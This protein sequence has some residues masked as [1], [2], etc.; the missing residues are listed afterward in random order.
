MRIAARKRDNEKKICRDDK[1]DLVELTAACFQHFTSYKISFQSIRFSTSITRTLTYQMEMQASCCTSVYQEKMGLFATVLEKTKFSKTIHILSQ[2][3]TIDQINNALCIP[4]E[5]YG[6]P[7]FSTKC[8]LSQR[9]VR[10]PVYLKDEPTVIYDRT[11]LEILLSK[12]PKGKIPG[13]SY[14]ASEAR[15]NI[16]ACTHLQLAIE[17]RLLKVA[18]EMKAHLER[19]SQLN[20]LIPFPEI[21]IINLTCDHLHL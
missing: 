16:N 6:D 8:Y 15:G 1:Y 9:P 18:E 4:E 10:Y 5:L 21:K 12:N 20:R 13:S 11:S 7:F 17:K 14:D 3:Y 2:N 19:E